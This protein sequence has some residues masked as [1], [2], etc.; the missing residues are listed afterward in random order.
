VIKHALISVTPFPPDYVQNL[1]IFWFVSIFVKN[2]FTDMPIIMQNETK[3][4]THLKLLEMS[5]QT[6]TSEQARTW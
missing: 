4:L 5:S 3:D 6:D 1:C 2:V